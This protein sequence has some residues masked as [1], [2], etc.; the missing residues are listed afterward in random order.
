MGRGFRESDGGAGFRE[1][2]YV[3]S[4]LESQADRFKGFFLEEMQ[5]ISFAGFRV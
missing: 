5:R 3:A 2:K 1:L 4:C